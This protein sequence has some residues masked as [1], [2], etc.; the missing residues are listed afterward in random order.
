MWWDVAR[1]LSLLTLA[2]AHLEGATTDGDEHLLCELD[3]CTFELGEHL[4]ST[5]EHGSEFVHLAHEHTVCTGLLRCRSGWRSG[6]GPLGA[7]L[8]ADE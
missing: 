4:L 1:A 7:S 2:F 5:R 6:C 3:V 8:R